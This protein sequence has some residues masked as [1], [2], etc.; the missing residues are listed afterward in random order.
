MNK[1]VSM[2]SED[3][4][5]VQQFLLLRMNTGHHSFT[6]QGVDYTLDSVADVES[7]VCA[8]ENARWQVQQYRIKQA[9]RE[10]PGLLRQNATRLK[11]QAA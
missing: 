1:E 7:A 5:I 9:R 3:R 11:A 8:V 6:I 2:S 4:E 10:L